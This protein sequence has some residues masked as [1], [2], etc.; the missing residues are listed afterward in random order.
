VNGTSI[1]QAPPP[2]EVF[3]YYHLETEQHE[4]ILANGAPAETFCDNISREAFD[5]YAEFVALYPQGREI[6]E[7]DLPH[8]KSRRQVP[9]A[10]IARLDARARELTDLSAKSAA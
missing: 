4:V 5:N 8:A 6:G 9:A 7:M 1:L 10:I 3:R 2:A